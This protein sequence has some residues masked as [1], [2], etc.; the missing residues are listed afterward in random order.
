MVDVDSSTFRCACEPGWS[1][2]ACQ[3]AH[4]EMDIPIAFISGG[5]AGGQVCTCGGPPPNRLKPPADNNYILDGNLKLLPSH[6]V[7]LN[8]RKV[9]NS[10]PRGPLD[11]NYHS[12]MPVHA[13]YGPV[14][15][16]WHEQLQI[17]ST[18][19]FMRRGLHGE[20]VTLTDDVVSRDPINGEVLERRSYTLPD[21]SVKTYPWDSIISYNDFP[22]RCGNGQCVENRFQCQM[23]M[24]MFPVC[25][26]TWNVAWGWLV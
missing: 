16:Y 13:P 19:P 10:I 12:V 26:G 1:G 14:L 15:K 6:L 5:I 2:N 11:V 18:C 9:G 25:G 22:Y 23:S 3:Y 17:Y 8:Y 4:C 21:G 24:E 20:Y 7:E